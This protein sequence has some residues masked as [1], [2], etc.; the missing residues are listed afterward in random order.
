MTLKGQYALVTGGSRGIGRGIALKLAAAGVRIGVHYYQNENAAKETLAA[1]RGLGSDGL[2]VK[3]DVTRAEQVTRLLD[4][5]QSEFGRLNIFVSNARPEAAEFFVPPLAITLEQW[6][7]AVQSQATAFLIGAREAAKF[8]S[9]GGRIIAI[10]YAPG[11]RTGGLQPWVAMGAAKAALETLVRYF[12][13]SLAARGITVN[14]VSPGWTEDSVLNS[15]PDPVQTVIRDWHQRGWTPMKR[16]GTPADIG[17]VVTLLCQEEAGWIT[18]QLI[19]ADGGS[20]LM[21]SEVP[22]ELQLG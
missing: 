7:S 6:N 3:A 1:V 13:V 18:G 5:I 14:S 15:L 16:L 2:V 17:N 11:G 8:M 12:A 21:N 19:A 10:T 4:Q 20:S 9:D 22:P